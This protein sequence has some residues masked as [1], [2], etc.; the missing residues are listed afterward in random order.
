MA[1]VTTRNMPL[2]VPAIFKMVTMMWGAQ[3]GWT[4]CLNMMAVSPTQTYTLHGWNN[5][6][7]I[8]N[9]RLVLMEQ[10]AWKVC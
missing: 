6:Q 3:N 4:I 9:P 7:V 8:F 2:M 1:V 10:T 5:L